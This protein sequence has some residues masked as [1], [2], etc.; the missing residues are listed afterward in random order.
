MSNEIYAAEAQS[1]GTT[2]GLAMYEY[3]HG[4]NTFN[5]AIL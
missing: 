5:P 3:V 2:K 4:S 1:I